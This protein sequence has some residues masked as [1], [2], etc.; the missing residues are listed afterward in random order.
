MRE[1]PHSR[2]VG[3]ERSLF[4][5]V[6]QGLSHLFR[7]SLQKMGEQVERGIDLRRE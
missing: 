6:V 7:T 2:G 5:W 3:K 4:A 1:G